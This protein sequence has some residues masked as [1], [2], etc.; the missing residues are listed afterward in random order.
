[1]S[2]SSEQHRMELFH[3][4]TYHF[5]FSDH[6]STLFLLLFEQT[7]ENV[8]RHPMGK[9]MITSFL[10]IH[11]EE[12]IGNCSI[13]HLPCPGINNSAHVHS[14]LFKL[15]KQYYKFSTNLPRIKKKWFSRKISQFEEWKVSD[16]Q[17][18]L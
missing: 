11:I 9:K 8:Q 10:N 4:K 16:L 12:W 2:R 14:T 13:T 3:Q 6:R 5:C 7:W 15:I 1:M 18:W 17:K